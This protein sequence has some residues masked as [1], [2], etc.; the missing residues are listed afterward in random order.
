MKLVIPNEI[1]YGLQERY[2]TYTKK[3]GYMI[4]ANKPNGTYG[5]QVSFD[6]WRDHNIPAKDIGNDYQ[7]GFVLNKGHLNK[8]HFGASAKFRV[9]HPEGFE[10]E[11]SLENLSLLLDNSVISYGE[12]QVPCCI[13]WEGSNVYLL[14]KIDMKGKVE[15]EH[16]DVHA[17]KI[18]AEK[19]LNKI[20]N[21]GKPIPIRSLTSGKIVE[22]AEGNRFVVSAPTMSNFHREEIVS[23]MVTKEEN[24][25]KLCSKL[26]IT[27][28]INFN[29]DYPKTF[30]P[31]NN[32]NMVIKKDKENN[33]FKFV[34]KDDLTEI[35][36]SNLKNLSEQRVLLFNKE[37]NFVPL[38]VT[39]ESIGKFFD[40]LTLDYVGKKLSSYNEDN[41][42]VYI[43]NEVV[44]INGKLY[45]IFVGQNYR[46]GYGNYFL[47]DSLKKENEEIT[48]INRDN[49]RIRHLIEQVGAML[50][51][52]TS[53]NDK[54]YQGYNP[55]KERH[56]TL[57][58]SNEKN[59]TDEAINAFGENGVKMKKLYEERREIMINQLMTVLEPLTQD[60]IDNQS[61][62]FLEQ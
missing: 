40:Q 25:F 18:K 45:H 30:F 55:Q 52:L 61:R 2:D 9:F 44:K 16:F 10:F 59:V 41:G 21:S 17:N 15:I 46:M 58:V 19:R 37:Q 50:I 54:Y 56:Y 5:Q 24:M 53:E 49:Y 8:Y 39:K 13:A 7:S 6:G 31:L 35:E 20:N 4:Y 29:E 47:E 60:E 11:I 62:V 48:K 28:H 42:S 26:G 14:P 1:R 12:I 36:S 34:E 43:R 23:M 57:Y 38:E 3:L 32:V 51:P 33:F 27:Y 22:D